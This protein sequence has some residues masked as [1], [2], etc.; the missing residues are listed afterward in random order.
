M[1]VIIVAPSLDPA[2]NVSGVS[3]VADF[4]IRHNPTCRYQHFL[5]GKG[6][7]E[8]SLW[9]SRLWR[10]AGAYLR[11]RKLLRR[12]PRHL[13]HYNFPLD[14]P[15]ILRDFWFMTLAVS[16]HRR[17]VIHLHGG[18]YL[19][20]EKRPWIIQRLLSKVFSWEVPII[21]QSDKERAALTSQFRPGDVHVLPNCVDIA[22]DPSSHKDYDSSPLEIVY[23]GRIE[24]NKGTD[25]M[26]AAAEIMRDR[27]DD[28]ILHLAGKEQEEG[29]YI[30]RFE[31]ALGQRFRYEGIV[32]GKSKEALLRRCHVFLLPSL[33][34]G[35][36]ISLLECMS[37]GMAP[38]TT[39]VGSIS[40]VVDDGENGL[41]VGL[42]DPKGIAD[43]IASL[44]ADRR[45]LQVMGR[46]AQATI[47]ERFS[48]ER[49][50][51]VLNHLYDT[52]QSA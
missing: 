18:L 31:Q 12:H 6:D 45:R 40:T 5:Q 4:I 38:V 36:P 48:P 8:S 30:P 33:Y 20:K 16:M 26:L 39:D 29:R 35:L 42:K 47:L 10:I 37:Y 50:I 41:L 51:S 11:W 44:H 28:F 9:A 7:T 43:A 34:E 2:V 49:Y 3:A 23:L 32:S 46:R 52:T 21:V 22:D 25:D 17:M 1:D 15:S 14:A 13:I 19:S 24:P 27:G